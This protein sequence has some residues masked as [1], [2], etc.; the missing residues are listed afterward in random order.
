M[1]AKKE[2]ALTESMKI[3]RAM[4]AT[5]ILLQD[6][7]AEQKDLNGRITALGWEVDRL[8]KDYRQL[9]DSL[10]VELTKEATPPQNPAT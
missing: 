4:K 10:D 7:R 2:Q 5:L 3:M 1:K 9:R 8:E 6:K